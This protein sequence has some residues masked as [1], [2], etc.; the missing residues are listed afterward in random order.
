MKY[1]NKKNPSNEYE[2]LMAEL[3]DLIIEITNKF[4][5]SKSEKKDYV[6]FTCLHNVGTNYL[7]QIT[8][9]NCLILPDNDMKLDYIENVREGIN[10]LLDAIQDEIKNDSLH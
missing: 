10:T 6:I 9:G 5:S 2:E 8:K 7:Y 1:F 4:V 3:L